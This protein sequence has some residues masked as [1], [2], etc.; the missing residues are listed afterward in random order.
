MK[1]GE[2][3]L[4]DQFILTKWSPYFIVMKKPVC[5]TEHVLLIEYNILIFP[6][7]Q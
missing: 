4:C 2:I 7:L 3:I 6:K 1:S 5:Y